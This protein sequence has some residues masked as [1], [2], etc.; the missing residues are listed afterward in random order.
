MKRTFFGA[1]ALLLLPAGPYAL[2]TGSLSA[3]TPVEPQPAPPGIQ[4][5]PAGLQP[6][7]ATPQGTPAAQY[8]APLMNFGD[9]NGIMGGLTGGG[10][11]YY[12]K[13]AM[14]ANTA[15]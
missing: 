5:A 11:F 9:P 12:L 2:M 10:T 14:P 13:P 8:V 6:V 15:Y 7:P 4:I 1:I 3:Q